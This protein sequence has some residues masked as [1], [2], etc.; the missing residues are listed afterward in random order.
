MWSTGVGRRSASRVIR[1]RISA[2]L[3]WM[4]WEDLDISVL[5]SGDGAA[6]L[7]NLTDDG[8]GSSCPKACATNV[9]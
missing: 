8:C 7:I 6:T 5:E 2:T 1:R 3:R 9:G 4:S